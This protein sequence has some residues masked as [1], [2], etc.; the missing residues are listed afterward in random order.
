MEHMNTPNT[1]HHVHLSL[2]WTGAE[3]CDV[4]VFFVPVMCYGE[5]KTC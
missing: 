4:A 5:E 2:I 3:G 1:S